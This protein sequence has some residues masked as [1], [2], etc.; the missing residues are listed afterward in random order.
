M[1]ETLVISGKTETIFD[2][3]DFARILYERLG[4][5]AERYFLDRTDR[6]AIG[7]DIVAE[8]T[9]DDAIEHICGGECDRTQEIQREYEQILHEVQDMLEEIDF[10]AKKS[11]IEKQ[12]KG[13]WEKINSVL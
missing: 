11:D 9:S 5:D 8:L 4:S 3:A 7:D 10:T 6:E 1:T 13:I 2:E 12:C